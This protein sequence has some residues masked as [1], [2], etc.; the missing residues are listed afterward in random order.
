VEDADL[1][2]D[3]E[4]LEEEGV[5]VGGR[6]YVVFEGT[7]AGR[8]VPLPLGSP[9]SHLQDSEQP[10]PLSVLPSSHSAPKVGSQMPSP[11]FAGVAPW[12]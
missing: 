12:G 6:M 1:D 4:E 8:Q 11:H 5:E 9:D 10:S 7:G 2:V 3:V